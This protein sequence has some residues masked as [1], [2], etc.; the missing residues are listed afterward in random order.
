MSPSDPAPAANTYGAPNALQWHLLSHTR[1]R[2]CARARDSVP[3]SNVLT[4]AVPKPPFLLTVAPQ[5]GSLRVWGVRLPAASVFKAHLG[6]SG[7]LHFH[8]NSRVNLSIFHESQL[9]LAQVI[10]NL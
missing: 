10:L 1:G 6:Y 8:V 3:L 9:R 4:S 5:S 2:G 7:P